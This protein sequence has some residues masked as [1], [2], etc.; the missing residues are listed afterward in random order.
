MAVDSTSGTVLPVAADGSALGMAILYNDMRAQDEAEACAAVFGGACSP[1]FG[2][3]K[4][5][6]MKAQM[7]FSGGLFSFCM[8]PTF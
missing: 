2:L 7:D 4:I 1:T 8:R 6:W 3:P 5:L